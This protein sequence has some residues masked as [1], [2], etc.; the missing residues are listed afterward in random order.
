MRKKDNN[1]PNKV[2][3]M[4]ISLFVLVFLIRVLFELVYSLF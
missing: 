4:F 2:W 3:G 1:H